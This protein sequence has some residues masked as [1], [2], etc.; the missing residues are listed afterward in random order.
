MIIPIKHRVDWELLCQQKETQINK[1]NIQG[2]N[3]TVD[4]DYK[5]V[6]KSMLDNHAA[7]KY[8][9]PYKRPFVITQWWTNGTFTLQCGAIKIRYNFMSY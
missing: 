9:T 7:Y 5:V 8:E 6:A 2:N 1:N 4:H 3:K